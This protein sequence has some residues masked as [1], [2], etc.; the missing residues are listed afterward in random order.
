[1][2]ASV[3]TAVSRVHWRYASLLTMGVNSLAG[4]ELLL[5]RGLVMMR[6]MIVIEI[7]VIW[8]Y[9]DGWVFSVRS[10]V[11]SIDRRPAVVITA[12]GLLGLDETVLLK[13]VHPGVDGD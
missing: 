3:E 9:R 11:G 13:P 5:K 8:G 2:L 12:I 7:V 6:V 1:M 10:I 4:N